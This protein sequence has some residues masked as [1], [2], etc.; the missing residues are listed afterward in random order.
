MHGDVETASLILATNFESV[1]KT[2]PWLGQ[3]LKR[4]G[5][6]LVLEFLHGSHSSSS[7]EISN[8]LSN[9]TNQN[10]KS[11]ASPVINSIVD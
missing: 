10:R 11:S 1:L 9:P 4:N 6:D 8:I 7:I 5:K 2:N 3:K